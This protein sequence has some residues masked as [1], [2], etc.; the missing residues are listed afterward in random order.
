MTKE[1]ESDVAL[2]TRW[3]HDVP[4]HPQPGV[5]FRDLTP[6]WAEGDVWRRAADALARDFVAK[7]GK[8]PDFV[9]AVEARGFLVGQALA[10]RWG[11]GILLA[12]KP[13]KL[14]RAA[15]RRSYELEYGEAG[16][17]LH[18]DP[19]PTGGTLVV[20]DDV[21]ATGGTAEAALHLA[22]ELEAQVLGFCFLV[23]LATLGG[24]DRLGALPISSLIIYREGGTDLLP[25]A[26]P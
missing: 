6:L 26:S 24:R 9:L 1:T 3:V 15:Y 7:A 2:W 25:P 5:I 4:D 11:A 12:R 21:L 22:E 14:P 13:G 8:A 16:L 18:E 20:A 17:E 10:D 19:L 23:E